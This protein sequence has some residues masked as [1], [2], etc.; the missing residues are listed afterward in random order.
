MAHDHSPRGNLWGD[1][2]STISLRTKQRR[3]SRAGTTQRQTAFSKR[4]NLRSND[5][6]NHLRS[7]CLETQLFQHHFRRHRAG[8]LQLATLLVL[9]D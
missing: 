8:I 3:E 6:T 4:V 5:H 9:L 1:A 7:S 2:L